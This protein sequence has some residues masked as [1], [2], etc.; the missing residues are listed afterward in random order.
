MLGAMFRRFGAVGAAWAW[1]LAGVSC[2]L[3]GGACKS[4]KQHPGV[5]SDKDVEVQSTPQG[6]V[7]NTKDGKSTLRLDT[8]SGKAP[9]DWPKEVPM[10]PGSKIDMSLKLGSGYTLTQ[11]TPDPLAKV[12]EFY[13]AQL[14]RMQ[15]RSSVDMGQSQTLQW[16]DEQQPLQV[17]LALNA[18]DGSKPTRATLILTRD[19]NQPSAAGGASH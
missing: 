18:G 3:L 12:A 4:E 6:V 19:H 7:I 10:Y 5:V 1:F 13:K 14:S 9:E 8:T 2:A 16:S 15:A 17:T 11:E